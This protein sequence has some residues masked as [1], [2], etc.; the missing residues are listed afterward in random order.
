MKAVKVYKIHTF[1]WTNNKKRKF[2]IWIWF[3]LYRS[4]GKCCQTFCD[5]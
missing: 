2:E 4:Y 1:L 5:L 3:C